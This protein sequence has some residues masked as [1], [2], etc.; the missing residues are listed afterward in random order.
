MKKIINGILWRNGRFVKDRCLYF[1]DRIMDQTQQGPVSEIIDAKGAYVLPGFIDLHIHGYKGDDVMDGTHE[2][3]RRISKALCENGV[4]AFLPTTMTMPLDTIR[5]ALD[6][7]RQA[8]LSEPQGAMV[9]GAHLEGP[10][11]HMSK[12]GAQ[13]GSHIIQP[14]EDLVKSYEDILKVIT[15]APEVKGG[16]EM[17]QKYGHKI[18]VSLGHSTASYEVAQEAYNAGAKGTTHLFNAMTGLNHREPGLVG[19]AMSCGCYCEVIGD[20]IHLHTGIYELLTKM[21]G[22]DK[23]LLVTDCIQAGGMGDGNYSLGGQAVKVTQGK[24][25][26]DDGTLAGSVLKL[27]DGLKNFTSATSH[28]LEDLIPL[29]TENQAKYLGLDVEMG[30]LDIGKLANITL[31]DEAFNIK[32]TYVRGIRMYEDKV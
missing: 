14:D 17:I 6:V 5:K 22:L 23:L 10:F 32:E 9:L 24:C 30:T 26:L 13:S 2:G 25:T 28:S 3:L 8:S 11:I 15:L 29:V 27:K 18:N 4:T 1:D 7:I 16:L 19:A 31:M 21:K 20:N 12:K